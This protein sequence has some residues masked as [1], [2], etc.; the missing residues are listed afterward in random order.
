MEALLK[1][2]EDFG[3]ATQYIT[4]TIGLGFIVFIFLKVVDV[5]GDVLGYVLTFAP[6]WLPFTL[7]FLFFEAW[8][9]YVRKEYDLS[10]GRVTLEI[11]L[12]QEIQKSPQAM[13][14][15]INQLYQTASPDNHIQTY[16]DGKHP[17]KFSFEIVSRHG[18][19]RFYINTVEKKFKNLVEIQ[20]YAQY[21]GIEVHTLDIDY[22]AE[23]PWD[24]KRFAYFSVHFGL[25]KADAY[26]IKTYIDFGLDQMP[27][28]EEKIDPLT[29][30]L[31]NLGSLGP[32]E[33]MWVQILF[34][35]N[36]KEK[37][38]TGSLSETS[39]WTADARKE[40]NKIIANA[41]KR[42]GIKEEELKDKGTNMNQLLTDAEKDIIKAIERS[43]G[44]PGYNTNI[45]VMYIAEGDKFVGERIGHFI[46]MWRAFDD[47]NR[48]SI[49]FKWRTD[50]DWNW[51]QDP[52]GHKRMHMK[53]HEL[54]SYKRRYFHPETAADAAKVLTNEE[55]ATIY[56]FPGKVVTT[57]G[58]GR[59]PSKR[60]EAP[61][62]LPTR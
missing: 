28:E 11:R 39:D 61:S 12:P 53:E 50:F 37:F 54:D 56:H 24:P 14:M 16:I 34:E 26:P 60:S 57:P 43:L 32:G 46:T 2:L 22:T 30:V 23:I 6:L 19:V 9:E 8:M 52:T 13:E 21:P 42:V 27:E 40:I 51:W 49:G 55:L 35:V 48:N 29:S 38:K 41:A 10:Q 62:N 5:P 25:M 47:L 59:I 31:E 17:P 18:D 7:F 58:L 36:R 44:K 3:V 4:A 1:K 45:R 20:L 15:V 33:H